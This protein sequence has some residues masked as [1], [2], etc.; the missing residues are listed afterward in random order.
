MHFR[1]HT[2]PQRC[3]VTIPSLRFGQKTGGPPKFHQRT[4]RSIHSLIKH[5]RQLHLRCLGSGCAFGGGKVH[6]LAT[7]NTPPFSVSV[8][9]ICIW[10]HFSIQVY[11]TTTLYMRCPSAMWRFCTVFFLLRPLNVLETNTSIAICS[12]T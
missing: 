7:L 11:Q 8:G 1:T 12:R 3:S 10:R 2:P 6:P 4:Q 5:K 9:V